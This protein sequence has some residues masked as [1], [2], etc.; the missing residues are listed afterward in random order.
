LYNIQ[1]FVNI[2]CYSQLYT[3]ISFLSPTTLLV[4]AKSIIII[5]SKMKLKK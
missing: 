1:N 5:L 2:I 4:W 3:K